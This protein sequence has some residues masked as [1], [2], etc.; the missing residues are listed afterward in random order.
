MIKLTSFTQQRYVI[1][2]L[3][4]TTVLLHLSSSPLDKSEIARHLTIFYI[5]CSCLEIGPRS[6]ILWIRLLPYGLCP[7][8]VLIYLQLLTRIDWDGEHL[9]L[10]MLLLRLSL[11]PLQILKIEQ[12][13]ILKVRYFDLYILSLLIMIELCLY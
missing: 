3:W 2:T 8:L 4:A 11:V 9:M 6:P 10:E 5:W 12:G 7:I 13:P 1:L